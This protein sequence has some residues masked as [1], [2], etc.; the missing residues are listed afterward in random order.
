VF[1]ETS[2]REQFQGRYV[3]THPYRGQLTCSAAT[4]YRKK[5]ASRQR[6]EAQN[7]SQLTGWSI[8]DIQKK[9]QPLMATNANGVE[10]PFW[11]W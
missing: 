8:A 5:V 10:E 6:Q 7:L 11:P 9:I 4:N 3:M 1:Q 2:D